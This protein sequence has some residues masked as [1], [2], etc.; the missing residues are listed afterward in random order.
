MISCAVVI[1]GGEGKRMRESGATVP[2]PFVE[3]NNKM[4]IS[5]I[6]DSLI[7]N[8][9]NEIIIIEPYFYSLESTLKQ[10][11]PNVNFKF[12]KPRKKQSL[13]K[14][15]IKIEKLIKNDF[16]LADSDIIINEQS[17]QTFIENYNSLKKFSSIAAVKE[18][19][20]ENNHY[21]AFPFSGDLPNPG[22]EPTSPAL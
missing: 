20:F 8:N 18:P 15:L 2:K 11:Y 7:N 16:I 22:M 13:I 5:Y 3:V 14:N 10:L 9:I 4:L 17:I 1:A 19:K 6:L 12:Y 21:L